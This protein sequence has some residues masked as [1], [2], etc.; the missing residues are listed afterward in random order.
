MTKPRRDP[1][2]SRMNSIVSC[3]EV[4]QWA[5]LWLMEAELL[6]SRGRRCT[7][8]V[9]WSIV[10]RAAARMTSVFAACRDLANAPSQ[11]AVFDALEAGLPRTLRVLEK[12]LNWAM[13][14]SWPRRLQRRCWQVAIDWHLIPYYGEP[15]KSRNE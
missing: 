15:H 3:S 14:S 12:R 9:V 6:K 1:M 2:R 10:L 11:Q 5:L 13:T 4:H 8:T 7:P